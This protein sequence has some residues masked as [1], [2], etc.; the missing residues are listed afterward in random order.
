MK[1]F[2]SPSSPCAPCE[3]SKIDKFVI[4]KAPGSNSK[5]INHQHY[6]FFSAKFWDGN[7]ETLP[8]ALSRAETDDY[9]FYDITWFGD[10]PDATTQAALFAEADAAIELYSRTADDYDSGYDAGYEVG[11][12]D[13]SNAGFEDGYNAGYDSGFEDGRY[14]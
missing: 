5:Y 9:S 10:K 6:P 13:G 3:N 1:T 12:D 14:S 4:G 8:C 11:C 2:V 7:E